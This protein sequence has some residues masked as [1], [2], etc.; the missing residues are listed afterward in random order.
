MDRTVPAGAALLLDFI[1]RADAG[2][3]PPDCYLTIFGNRQKYLPKPLTS[4]TLGEVID[5]Q[6]NWSNRAWV[7]KNWS[8]GAKAASSAAGAAQFMRDTLIGL[9]KEFSLSGMQPFDP[10]FQDRMAF[11]LLLRRGY[12]DFMAGKISRTEFG[13]R[14]A[15]EWASFP[16]LAPCQGAHGR[17]KRGQS[18]Y[19]GDGLN[20]ALVLPADVE[21][22][23]DRVKATK[24]APQPAQEAPKPVPATPE[25]PKAQP[26][27][28]PAPV[29]KR[30]LLQIIIEALK[31]LAAA[32]TGRK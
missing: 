24:S 15:Q 7:R 13:K 27:P 26:A 9:A 21:A 30:S 8:A 32:I 11:K 25:P 16:V 17:L 29:A 19:D 31:A 1:Y 4:M 12:N 5:A 2:H 22:M 3:A 18:Y 23:L 6:K 28:T 20:S 14:L 10:D